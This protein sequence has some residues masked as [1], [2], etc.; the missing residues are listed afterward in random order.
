MLYVEV[1]LDNDDWGLLDSYASL[2][3]F[4]FILDYPTRRP[5]KNFYPF[6]F[7]SNDDLVPCYL[8]YMQ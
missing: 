3:I 6:L 7:P 2:F 8:L 5:G 4:T 1:M